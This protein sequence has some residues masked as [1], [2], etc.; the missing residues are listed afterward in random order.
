MGDECYDVLDPFLTPEHFH[1]QLVD[2]LGLQFDTIKTKQLF[3]L[4]DLDRDGRVTRSEFLNMF[5]CI[6]PSSRLTEGS[7]ESTNACE[8]IAAE[9]AKLQLTRLQNRVVL[10]ERELQQY[11]SPMSNMHTSDGAPMV[12]EKQYQQA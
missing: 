11:R 6:S 4:I 2:R 3:S 9:G 5:R 1:E 8:Q 7:A 10:M 12:P